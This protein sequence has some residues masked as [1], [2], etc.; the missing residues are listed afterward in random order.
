MAFTAYK[1]CISF[2]K[3]IQVVFKKG[4]GDKDAVSK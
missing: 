1:H 2:L 3:N 4:M